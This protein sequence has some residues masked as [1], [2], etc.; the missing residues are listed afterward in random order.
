MIRRSRVVIVICPS[1]EDTVR[2]DRAAR[3]DRADRERAGLGRGRWRRP[4]RR[5]AVRR[6]LGLAERRRSCSTRARSRPIRDSTCCSTRWRSCAA[7]AR[8]RGWCWPAASR[9]RSSARATRRA[10]A[11]IGDVAIFAGERPAA[12]IPAYLLAADV[13]VSP[14]SRG[15]NTPLKIYQYLRSGKADRRDAPADAHAG[16]ERRHRDSHRRVADGVRRRASSRRST[17]AT[18]RAAVGRQARDARRD[19]VQLRGLSRTNAAGVRGALMSPAALSARCV[20]GRRVTARRRR[21][22]QLHALRRPGDGARRSTSAGSADRSASSSPAR[23]RACSP[24]FVGPDQRADAFSMSAPAP[25]ARRC[26][27]RGGGARV[28]GRRRVGGD[29]RGR[30]RSGPPTRRR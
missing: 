24:N 20:E 6:T 8:T 15:T 13:L 23:R 25:G 9:I 5:R 14:R 10:S 17:I 16:A 21:S 30:A 28:T 1:L 7:R 19:Q 22:L 11:G 26:C 3:A 4:S 12:E 29:A 18:A 2:G 27:W